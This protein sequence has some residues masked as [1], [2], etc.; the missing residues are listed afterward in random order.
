MRNRFGRGRQ[1]LLIDVVGPRLHGAEDA[2]AALR[3]SA[4]RQDHGTIVVLV[5]DVDDR[6]VLAVA[7]DGA[8]AAKVMAVVECVLLAGAQAAGEPGALVVGLFPANGSTELDRLEL[9]A[10]Q[11]MAWECEDRAVALLDVFVIGT[12]RWKGIP[13]LGTE[14][15]ECAGDAGGSSSFST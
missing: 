7:F 4:G 13:D 8:P 5:C 9:A 2:V 3:V 14:G 12:H 1:P 10:V 11:E 15:F 6:V